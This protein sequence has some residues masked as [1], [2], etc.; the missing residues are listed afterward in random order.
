MLNDG[1]HGG[2]S[3]T[4]AQ[5]GLSGFAAGPFLVLFQAYFYN[6]LVQ[7]FGLIAML[8]Y[9]V[10]LFSILLAATPMQSL[11]IGWGQPLQ[12]IVLYTHSVL[13]NVTRVTAFI[14]VFVVVA[15]SALPEDR[16][17]VNGLGQAAVSLVRA[18]GPPL[19]TAAF[20]IS[21][22]PMATALGWPFNYHAVW[23][24]LAALSVGTLALTY[25]L[26]DW[27]SGKRP[28]HER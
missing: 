26:P 9:S 22:S 15:N 24:A 5:V 1:A 27:I 17:R 20:A 25:E 19:G 6:K 3:W 14:C 8:R 13:I 4:S 10:A 16:G 2:F 23:Y 21:V 18:L 7:R 28:P 12:D 11:S